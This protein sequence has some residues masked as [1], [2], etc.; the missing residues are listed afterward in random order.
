MKDNYDFSKAVKNPYA[1]KLKREGHTVMINYGVKQD[2]QDNTGEYDPLPDEKAAF[3]EYYLSNR[4]GQ[5]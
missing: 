3:E 1:A 5:R 2:E 4:Q